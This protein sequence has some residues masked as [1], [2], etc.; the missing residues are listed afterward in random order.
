MR[1]RRACSAPCT[2]A[3]GSFPEAFRIAEWMLWFSM[4]QFPSQGRPTCPRLLR[5]HDAQSR[6]VLARQFGPARRGVVLLHHVGHLRIDAHLSE[7][8]LD[9]I[10]KLNVPPV[11]TRLDALE[12][13]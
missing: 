10:A 5:R 9:E 6:D 1:R 7:V 11:A 12:P 4:Q 13:D 2:S 8:Q 3:S